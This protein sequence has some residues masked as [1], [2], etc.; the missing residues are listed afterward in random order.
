MTDK[1]AAGMILKAMI[2]IPIGQQIED[3]EAKG[4]ELVSKLCLIPK[5][6]RDRKLADLIL[7]GF[8]CLKDFDDLFFQMNLPEGWRILA[9]R[10]GS[11]WSTILDELGKIRYRLFYKAA[12]YDRRAFI[13]RVTDTEALREA[14]L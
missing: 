4:Q 10:K 3:Q 6:V 12:C 13:V 8:V 7:E 9:S 14:I 1:D 5:D 2:G 11:Y